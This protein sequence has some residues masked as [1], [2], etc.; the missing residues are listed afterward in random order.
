MTDI[1]DDRATGG[2][3]VFAPFGVAD[4]R[5]VGLHGDRRFGD[6]RAA[7]DAAS[8]HPG[9][10]ADEAPGPGRSAGPGTRRRGGQARTVA[11]STIGFTTVMSVSIVS[12]S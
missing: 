6:G 9:I 11:A 5:A 12:E 8:A 1:D 10:V 2:V 4:G 3:E 7:E